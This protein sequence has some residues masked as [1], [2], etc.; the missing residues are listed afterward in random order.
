MPF[1]IGTSINETDAL[2]PV[3]ASAPFRLADWLVE[4]SLNCISRDSTTVKVDGRH[5]RVLLLLAKHAGEIVS[6]QQIEDEVWRDESVTQN[7]IHQAIA[8][9]R[10]GLGDDRKAPRY[11]ETVAR[12]G[13]RLVASVD[14]NHCISTGASCEPEALTEPDPTLS[15]PEERPPI[16]D[17][18]AGTAPKTH[19]SQTW[20]SVF[21]SLKAGM[22]TLNIRRHSHH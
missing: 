5:M 18:P 9:L 13:Y 6:V 4:P 10:K 2:N 12:K 7:S 14:W 16:L 3:D 22:I 11:I 1:A 8:Q 15:A 19:R 21:S 17:R 20:A